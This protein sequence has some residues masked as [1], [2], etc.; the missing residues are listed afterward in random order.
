ME[1]AGPGSVLVGPGLNQFGAALA[2]GDQSV[3]AALDAAR[4]GPWEVWLA[5]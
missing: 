1:S 2:G 5:G 4:L 3:V